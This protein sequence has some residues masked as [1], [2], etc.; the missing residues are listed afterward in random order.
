MYALFLNGIPYLA[1]P[2]IVQHPSISSSQTARLWLLRTGI[3]YAV[4][5]CITFAFP[6]HIIPQTG[7]WLRGIFDEMARLT[8]IYLFGLQPGFTHQLVS[9]S[10]GFYLHLFNIALLSVLAALIWTALS[11]RNT[12]G[13]ELRQGVITLLRYY[14][15]LHLLVYGFT[16][17]FKWQ[18]YLPEPNIVYTRLGQ[19]HGDI[20]YWSLMGIS[21]SYSIFLGLAEV[22][23]GTLLLFRKTVPAGALFSL[24]IMVNVFA[25]NLVYDIS[26][27]IHSGSLLIISVILL[28]PYAAKIF[29]FMSFVRVEP[30]PQNRPAWT[31]RKF[32]RPLKAAVILAMLAESLYPGFNGRNW[33]DDAAERPFLHGAWQVDIF[34]ADGDTLP[35]L[36]TGT[37][38]WKRVFFHRQH[39]LITE[40]MNDDMVDYA[41]EY[42]TA[43]KRIYV[44]HYADSLQRPLHYELLNDSMLVLYGQLNG[45]DMEAYLSRLPYK[46]LPLLKREF[47]WTA[48]E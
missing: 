41:L 25:L 39:Y 6:Y 38:R 22:L 36:L 35:P 12:H 14:L 37:L 44:S 20:A 7:V 13:T 8:G 5:F 47:N 46:T 10:T 17:V 23:A 1:G 24:G 34:V 30:L 45:M 27:K 2:T 3:I 48:D 40:M 32:W 19:L 4:L 42:D 15:A 31:Q 29:R 18:F 43:H 33:N 21:R 28:W 11:H 26:V 16:K 9:D